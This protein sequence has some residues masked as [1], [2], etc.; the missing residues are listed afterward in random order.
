[1]WCWRRIEKISWSD[2]V[3]NGEVLLSV[4]VSYILHAIKIMKFNWAG[5]ILRWNCLLK[6][7]IE[8]KIE[9]FFVRVTV[10]HRDM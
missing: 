6:R 2:R 9:E 8:N 10:L 3:R 4:K 5:Y 1:M 7:V